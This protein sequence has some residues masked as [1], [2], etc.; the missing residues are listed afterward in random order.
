MVQLTAAGMLDVVAGIELFE[1]LTGK[2]GVKKVRFTGG[3][4]ES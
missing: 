3:I 1:V 4:S 2:D